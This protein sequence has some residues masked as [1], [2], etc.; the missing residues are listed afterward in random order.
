MSSQS[1]EYTIV[2]DWLHAALEPLQQNELGIREGAP[3]SVKLGCCAG[4]RPHPEGD[5]EA[6]PSMAVTPKRNGRF[7]IMLYLFTFR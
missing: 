5:R 1:S 4:K 3:I 6:A 7:L 2:S